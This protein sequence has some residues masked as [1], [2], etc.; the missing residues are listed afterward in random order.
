V[1]ATVVFTQ[2]TGHVLA[3]LSRAS[4]APDELTV[5][6]LVRGALVAT[7]LGFERPFSV[8]ELGTSRA[9]LDLQQ[10]LDPT[11]LYVAAEAT[12]GARREV[13]RVIGSGGI[14]ATVNGSQ[15]TVDCQSLNTTELPME[16]WTKDDF[17]TGKLLPSATAGRMVGTVNITIKND[18]YVVLVDGF[19]PFTPESE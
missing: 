14:V 3:V 10:I 18:L 11:A 5:T 6:D 7:V 1:N 2:T 9:D 13:R 19:S 12:D 16:V 17:V 15:L 8:N 4:G